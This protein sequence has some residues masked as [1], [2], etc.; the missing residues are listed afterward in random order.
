M[1]TVRQTQVPHDRT[2]TTSALRSEMVTAIV[3]LS[4]HV[5][6]LITDMKFI[7]TKVAVA[8]SK[9]THLLSVSYYSRVLIEIESTVL[10]F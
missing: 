6:R 2:S 3:K 4:R 7:K 9:T 8:S 10:C 5:F 1:S